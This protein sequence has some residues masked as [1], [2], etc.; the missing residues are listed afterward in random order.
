M[1]TA[2][3]KITGEF[4]IGSRICKSVQ[5]HLTPEED[6]F[7]KYFTSGSLKDDIKQNMSNFYYVINFRS[8]LTV[9]NPQTN[10][11]EFVT[12]WYEQILIKDSINN[13][14]CKNRAFVNPDTNKMAFSTAGTARSKESKIK[15]SE[16]AKQRY[17]MLSEEEKLAQI[18][19]MRCKNLQMLQDTP[20]LIKDK[21]NIT[22]S[23]RTD[24]EKFRT[25]SLKSD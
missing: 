4:Y 21:R 11:E 16:N 24:E 19:P 1:Y 3:N 25:K 8:N 17:N 6:L 23:L 2:I 14:L 20:E 18:A 15:Q 7:V 12:Y 13:S 9:K 10:R 5:T 22:L